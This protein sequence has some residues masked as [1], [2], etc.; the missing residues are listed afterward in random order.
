M[1]SI[2][3]TLK[4]V[5]KIKHCFGKLF[6]HCSTKSPDVNMTFFGKTKI[7]L[8]VHW[9]YFLALS[10]ELLPLI[11]WKNGRERGGTQSKFSEGDFSEG[12]FFLNFSLYS[13]YWIL[14]YIACFFS[15][16]LNCS[17]SSGF[18][19]G[20]FLTFQMVLNILFL[21]TSFDWYWKIILVNRLTGTMLCFTMRKCL[22]CEC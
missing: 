14:I 17:L 7:N 8:Q 3:R 15:S 11:F 20:S 9:Q 21:C 13:L 19:M 2:I 6:I 16:T 5:S 18:V 4:C 12:K 10:S 1:P 22:H